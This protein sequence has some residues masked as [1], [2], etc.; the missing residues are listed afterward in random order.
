MLPLKLNQRL[1]KIQKV[2][3]FFKV[4]FQ[5]SFVTL[6]CLNIL[7]W[8]VARGYIREGYLGFQ[9][10]FS[11]P[12]GVSLGD[13]MSLAS[14]IA[15]FGVELIPISL[16]MW[17]FYNLIKVFK[18]YEKGEVFLAENSRFI[19]LTGYA[20]LLNQL[21]APFQEALI[22][23]AVTFQNPVGERLIS[24]SFGTSQLEKIV[25]AGLIILISWIMEEAQILKDEERYTV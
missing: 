19:R 5:M 7:A 22:T 10:S 16:S 18:N 9:W 24:M 8:F 2:S 1:Q 15:V 11:L 14:S 13:K 12:G 3:A 23:L 17:A 4:A 20:I 25:V 21:T 6:P